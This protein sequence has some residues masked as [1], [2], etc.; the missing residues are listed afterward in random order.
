MVVGIAAVYSLA[1][2]ITEVA[3]AC[4]EN[5]PLNKDAVQLQKLPCSTY[6]SSANA[7]SA[8]LA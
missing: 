2:S 5:K 3:R 6:H 1:A 8:T 7:L 4:P